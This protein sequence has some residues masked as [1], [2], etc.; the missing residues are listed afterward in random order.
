MHLNGV[1]K[2]LDNENLNMQ[3]NFEG[4]LRLEISKHEEEVKIFK[5]EINAKEIRISELQHYFEEIIQ[6]LEIDIEKL[7]SQK[8]EEKKYLEGI[9]RQ[10]EEELQQIRSG[11]FNSEESI[12]NLKL[13]ISKLEGELK[14]LREQVTNKDNKIIE[15]QQYFE[16]IVQKLEIELQQLRKQKEEEKN[17]L[18]GIIRQLEK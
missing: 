8:V 12:N 14:I 9:I 3:H 10:L 18:E 16:C 7:A 2:E 4:R 5:E 13:Q 1:I 6:N 17:H 15:L 11:K